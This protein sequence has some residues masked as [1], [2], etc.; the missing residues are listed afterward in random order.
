MDSCRSD[1]QPGSKDSKGVSCLFLGPG[2]W[3]PVGTGGS[4]YHLAKNMLRLD[5][6]ALKMMKLSGQCYSIECDGA[7]SLSTLH[8]TIFASRGVPT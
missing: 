3:L 2:Y 8:F 6:D 1:D 4:R 5:S 7:N